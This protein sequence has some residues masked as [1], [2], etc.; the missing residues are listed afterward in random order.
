MITYKIIRY[1]F[2]HGSEVKQAGLT[3]AEAR[4]WC[5]R[6][7]TKGVTEDG[8]EWFDGYTKENKR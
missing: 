5:N 3:L 7:D 2:E 8:V 1:Y 4:A 6:E